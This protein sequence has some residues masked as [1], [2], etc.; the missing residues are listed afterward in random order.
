MYAILIPNVYSD[1]KYMNPI[2]VQLVSVHLSNK[3]SNYSQIVH[4]VLL[5]YNKNTNNTTFKCI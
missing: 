3:N 2:S 5:K 1:V 4:K